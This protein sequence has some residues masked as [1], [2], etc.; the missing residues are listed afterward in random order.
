MTYFENMKIGNST[1]IKRKGKD[2]KGGQY[3]WGDISYGIE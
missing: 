1:L 3:I 2:S